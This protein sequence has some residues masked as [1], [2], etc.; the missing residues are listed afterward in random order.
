MIFADGRQGC[1]RTSG[2][3]CNSDEECPKSCASGRCDFTSGKGRCAQN[4]GGQCNNEMI[5]TV[6]LV[7]D[8]GKCALELSNGKDCNDD[9]DCLFNIDNR[10]DGSFCESPSACMSVN[11]D[12]SGR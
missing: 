2:E 9:N 10:D 7:G 1:T 3:K 12:D 4:N 8:K 5:P 6:Q 11:C